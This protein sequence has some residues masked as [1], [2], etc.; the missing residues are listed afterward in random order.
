MDQQ[1]RLLATFHL[2][3]WNS[4][5]LQMKRPSQS[6]GV[7]HYHR[8]DLLAIDIPA[9]QIFTPSTHIYSAIS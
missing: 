7:L 1:K 5:A 8:S 4:P 3:R 9:H 2:N 6:S